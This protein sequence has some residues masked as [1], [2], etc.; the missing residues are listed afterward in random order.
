V[1]A[2]LGHG[3]RPVGVD[4]VDAVVDDAT[5][6]VGGRLGR[7]DVEAA[8]DLPGVG[9]DDLRGDPAP[10]QVLGDVDREAGLARGRGTADDDE[11]RERQASVPRS[12]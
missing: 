9:G 10:L 6:L 4:E 8:V 12:A 2:E 7:P 5:P 11:G 1:P 3:I